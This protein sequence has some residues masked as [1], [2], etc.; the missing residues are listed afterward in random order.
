MLL[1]ARIVSNLA[2]V[3]NELAKTFGQEG[4]TIGRSFEADWVLPDESSSLS[5]LHARIFYSAAAFY[6]EDTSTNGVFRIDATGSIPI[7]KTARLRDGDRL[8][9]GDYEVRIEI[10]E[11]QKRTLNDSGDLTWGF[12]ALKLD[13]PL[14]T[15]GRVAICSAQ[16]LFPDG[17]EFKIPEEI[18]PP[19]PLKVPLDTVNLTVYLTKDSTRSDKKTRVS[20]LLRQRDQDQLSYL[21]VARV[22][23]LLD[24]NTVLLDRQYIPQVTNCWVRQF[25]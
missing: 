4:G 2:Q 22:S 7:N 16:G 13:E 12:A 5:R 3:P 25:F 15:D 23:E 21:G 19:E 20:L 8:Q 18:D 9:F 1:T 24:N 17:T 14:L 6:V 10:N 11:T